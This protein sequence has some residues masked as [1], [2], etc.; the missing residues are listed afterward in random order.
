MDNTVF[1]PYSAFVC[2]AMPVPIFEGET[3][4]EILRSLQISIDHSQVETVLQIK[5]LLVNDQ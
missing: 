1:S 2:V 3:R 4:A 5:S